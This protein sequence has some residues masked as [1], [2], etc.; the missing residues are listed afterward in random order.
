MPCETLSILQNTLNPSQLRFLPRLNWACARSIYLMLVFSLVHCRWAQTP[1]YYRQESEGLNHTAPG[2]DGHFE[3]LVSD[4]QWGRLLFFKLYFQMKGHSVY[5]NCCVQ[6]FLISVVMTWLCVKWQVTSVLF[7]TLAC[8]ALLSMEFPR[9]EFWS[10]WPFPPPGDL[11]DPGI[12]PTCLMSPA[13]AGRFFT[14][15]QL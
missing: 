9:Q 8:Q 3:D 1:M 14:T 4:A 5:L 2:T 15:S 7:G 6:L 12:E 10:E 11:P 13:L